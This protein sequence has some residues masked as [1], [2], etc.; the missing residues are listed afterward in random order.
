MQELLIK[1]NSLYTDLQ[2]EQ[3]KETIKKIKREIRNIENK[4]KEEDK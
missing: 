3:D 1:L 2:Y 4:L